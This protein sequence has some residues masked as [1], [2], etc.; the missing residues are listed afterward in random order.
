M[1]VRNRKKIFGN[2][3]I[4][5][6]FLVFFVRVFF[7]KVLTVLFFNN[8]KTSLNFNFVCYGW[9]ID[10]CYILLQ[11]KKMCLNFRALHNY[12]NKTNKCRCCL[13]CY[14]IQE[15]KSNFEILKKRFMTWWQIQYQMNTSTIPIFSIS[16]RNGNILSKTCSVTRNPHKVTYCLKFIKKCFHEFFFKSYT[17]CI[18]KCPVILDKWQPFFSVLFKKDYIIILVVRDTT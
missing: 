1:V 3:S 8:K 10:F 17:N 15:K 14:S 2:F 16:Y 9:Y 12:V 18:W 5:N 4:E 6:S 11:Q 7:Q 13:T